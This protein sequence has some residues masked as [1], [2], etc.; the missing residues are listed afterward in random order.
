MLT[1]EKD[2]EELK[3]DLQKLDDWS[4]KWLIKFHPKICKYNKITKDDV[5]FNY[6]LQGQHLLQVQEETDI[7]VIMGD[8]LSFESHMIEEWWNSWLCKFRTA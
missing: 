8:Q 3:Q 7:G 4:K 2:K 1:K 6:T 5:Q